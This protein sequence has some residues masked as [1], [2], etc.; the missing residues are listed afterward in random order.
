VFELSGALAKES[1]T[2]VSGVTLLYGEPPEARKPPPRS[3][4]WRLYCF[5]GEAEA[6]P[7]LSL[8]GA[9]SFLVGRERRVCSVHTAH[10]SCSSQ[11]AVLQWRHTEK[12]DDIGLPKPG[13][14][15]YLL[16]L[17]STNGTRLNGEQVEAQR[18]FELLSGDALQFG[19]SSREYVVLD[20][21]SGR[22]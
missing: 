4:A 6:E 15:L 14:R 9:S 13:V 2:T 16:D 12:L 8:G 3:S 7:P 11:H 17:G 22:R 1:N 21:G 5:K 18:F 10:P 19:N 20:G